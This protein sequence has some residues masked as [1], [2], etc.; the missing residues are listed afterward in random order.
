MRNGSK[1][2]R[3]GRVALTRLLEIF[4]GF[5]MISPIVLGL[6]SSGGVPILS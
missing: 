4:I 6:T 2:R 5:A 1:D 3:H